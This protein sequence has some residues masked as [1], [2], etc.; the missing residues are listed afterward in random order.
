MKTKIKSTLIDTS[1]AKL[2]MRALLDGHILKNDN[3]RC[4]K[5]DPDSNEI[6][7]LSSRYDGNVDWK[8][9]NISVNSLLKSCNTLAYEEI[10]CEWYENI[11]KEGI[12]CQ[13]WNDVSETDV[14]FAIIHKYLAT[15]LGEPFIHYSTGLKNVYYAHAKPVTIEA[16]SGYIYENQNR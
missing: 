8:K 9:D 3:K 6:S 5:L 12:L 11:P 13:V 16:L 2:A 15:N 7:L 1:N 14:R 10:K 4:Y